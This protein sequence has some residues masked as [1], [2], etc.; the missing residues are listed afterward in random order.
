M[1]VT[2]GNLSAHGKRGLRYERDRHHGGV[3]IRRHHQRPR[4][5]WS[6]RGMASYYG[7]GF[8]GKLT[9][10]GSRFNQNNLTAAHR[11]LPL[12]TSVRVSHGN[13]NVV[14]EINDRGPYANGRI[15]DLSKGAF[16]KLASL[17]EGL[18]NVQLI[19]LRH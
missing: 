7:P 15:I 4:K 13:K 10:S 18:I 12:G 14:V 3:V 19:V 8:H 9:A 2:V 1:L 11:T 17:D 5:H 6:Q 16:K